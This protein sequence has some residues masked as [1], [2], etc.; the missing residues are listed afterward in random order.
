MRSRIAL[1]GPIALVV[2][3]GCGGG[4]SPGGTPPPPTYAVGGTVTGLQGSGL[5]LQNSDTLLPV[6][7]NGAFMFPH[8]LAGGTFYSVAVQSQPSNPTQVCTVTNG[9]GTVGT[10]NTNN[11]AVTCVTPEGSLSWQTAVPIHQD[12]AHA[13]EG[14]R[15]ATN[16]HGT[17]ALVWRQRVVGDVVQ[18]WGSRY[19][20]ESRTWS[21]PAR[22][23]PQGGGI[24]LSPENSPEVAIAENGDTVVVWPQL[25]NGA[26][27][28]WERRYT[29]SGGWSAAV[30][31]DTA[32]AT[33]YARVVL[34]S[35]GNTLVTWQQLDDTSY[36][37]H[38]S[39]LAAGA[40]TWSA[41]VQIDTTTGTAG[42]TELVADGHGNVVAVWVQT[43]SP[44]AGSVFHVWSSIYRSST[45]TWGLP[46]VIGN[47][48]VQSAFYPHIAGNANGIA[49]ALWPQYD[50][51][52]WSNR[53]DPNAGWGTAAVVEAGGNGDQS[54]QLA[55]DQNGNV[56][57]VWERMD[58]N[59]PDSHIRYAAL[60]AGGSWAASAPL[61]AADAGASESTETPQIGFDAQ[62]NALAIWARSYGANTNA[63]SAVYI[64]G[65][66]WNAPVD[67]GNTGDIIDPALA[68][69]PNG[70]AAA[71]WQQDSNGVS[72]LWANLFE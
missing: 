70:T 64:P 69:A 59:P 13:E 37:V 5:V 23:G 68:V 1:A 32:T 42:S 2:C 33:A 34:D 12:E 54:P 16:A 49:Q 20:P 8:M 67:V 9:S 43:D 40:S 29:D 61:S 44:L 65:T 55:L 15:I 47:D 50:G 45:G 7:S 14:A 46:E 63:R 58:P 60:P 51:S 22:I 39:R 36:H 41:P 18:I 52:I 25:V 24:A 66:G 19:V 4:N 48:P 17:V 71:A 38:Y 28:I 72:N 26:Y 31:I 10:A 56:L 57:A 30:R 11:V 6:A 27:E 35:G 53:Y 21:A 3:V 62:G